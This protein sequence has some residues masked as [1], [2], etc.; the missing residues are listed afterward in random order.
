[1]PLINIK[2]IVSFSPNY[3]VI[4]ERE[5]L[6]HSAE[7]LFEAIRLAWLYMDDE[8]LVDACCGGNGELAKHSN[9]TLEEFLEIR[10]QL[11]IQ[12]ETANAKKLHTKTRRTEFNASRSQIVLALIENGVPYVCSQ[13]GCGQT[14][15]LTIDHIV[16]LSRGGTDELSNLRFLCPSHNS[17]KGDKHHA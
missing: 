11:R 2:G 6:N 17:S 13:S 3:G 4:V 16:P 5:A 10:E 15:E 9:L 14:T 8:Y 1:M 7:E 12:W